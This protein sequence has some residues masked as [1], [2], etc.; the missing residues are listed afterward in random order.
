MSPSPVASGRAALVGAV[1]LSVVLL[2]ATWFVNSQTASHAGADEAAPSGKS[3]TAPADP[4]RK[5]LA[6]A[7]LPDPIQLSGGRIFLN[8]NLYTPVKPGQEGDR[9]AR[10]NPSSEDDIRISGPANTRPRRWTGP[11]ELDISELRIDHRLTHVVLSISFADLNIQEGML[12][13]EFIITIDSNGDT[14]GERFVYITK[15]PFYRDGEVYTPR[16]YSAMRGCSFEVKWDRARN[17][18][19]GRIANSCLGNPA[20][21]RA[22]AHL[23]SP[24]YN[25][26]G[27]HAQDHPTRPQRSVWEALDTTNWTPFAGLGQSAMTRDPAQVMP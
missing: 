17:L 24:R 4:S 6:D 18:L 21:L 16:G 2:I 9:A 12:G 1:A 19:I 3:P 14:R 22:Q 7:V 11:W 5:T 23:R 10:A 27:L 15:Y 20:Q 8:G 26:F 25:V 13:D